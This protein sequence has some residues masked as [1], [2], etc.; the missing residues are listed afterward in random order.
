MR[1]QVTT[2]L[3]QKV[4]GLLCVTVSLKK[5]RWTEKAVKTCGEKVIA[6]VLQY[7]G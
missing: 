2:A 5:S 6:S 3:I 1:T 7:L 4:G